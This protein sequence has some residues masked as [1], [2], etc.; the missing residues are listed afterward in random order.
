M[1]AV[2]IVVMCCSV[3]FLTSG[4]SAALFSAN[5]DT[6]LNAQASPPNGSAVPAVTGSSVGITSGN[7]GYGGGEALSVTTD[8]DFL[9]YELDGTYPNTTWWPQQGSVSMKFK[10]G[11][12]DNG[13][14]IHM[15]TF[16]YDYAGAEN[17]GV[18]E[19]SLG[20]GNY[21]GA[22]FGGWAQLRTN[23]GWNDGWKTYNNGNQG[24]PALP[25]NP[26]V[27]PGWHDLRV[28]WNST[29]AWTPGGAVE[30]PTGNIAV[31]VDGLLGLA[32]NN[33]KLGAVE[34]FSRLRLGSGQPLGYYPIGNY[35][36]LYDQ[37]VIT[38]EPTTLTLLGLGLF[39]LL[40]SKRK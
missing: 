10:I 33:A 27:T 2:L 32:V 37:V 20:M 14:W 29:S 7:Q 22:N 8:R 13:N 36:G 15:F 18:F 40:R 9:T 1:K 28:E 30:T 11:Q 17:Y 16:H 4:A 19:V 21:D 26:M 25:G 12:P 5:F 34:T 24:Y 3:L 38:P 31:Y 35:G 6:S 39:G 23:N